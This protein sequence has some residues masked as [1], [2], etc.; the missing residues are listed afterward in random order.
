MPICT[1]EV[2]EFLGRA[3]ADGARETL[4]Q[5]LSLFL[6]LVGV[7]FALHTE[8]RVLQRKL[9]S[10]FGWGSILVT[11][12]IG[13]PIHELSHALACVVF[14]HRIR[15]LALFRPDLDT[16]VLGYVRHEWN[17][18]NPWARMGNFF[19]GVAP[20]AGGTAVLFLLLWVFFPGAAREAFSA[21]GGGAD[22]GAPDFLSA[23]SVPAEAALQVLGR[24]ANAET[25]T[26]WPFW[27]F[28]YL[29]V[30]VASHMGLSAEDFKHT[31]PVLA[32]FLLLVVLFLANAFAR[33]LGAGAGAPTLFLG[34]VLGPPLI[35]L[36]IGALLS[37][38]SCLAAAALARLPRGRR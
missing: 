31:R 29:V 36:G 7:A 4:V 28:L 15:E 6:P 11:G 20:L 32:A 13:T 21:W 27:L 30:C 23:V 18:D 8:A 2:G 33:A 19:I 14:G 22:R 25:P 12:W 5:A 10:R 3:A 37:G 38:G 26:W 35:L 9:A 34:R 17:P 24:L 16:G 1:A